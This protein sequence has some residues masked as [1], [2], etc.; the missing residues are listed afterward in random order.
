MI[1]KNHHVPS[2]A[3]GTWVQHPPWPAVDHGLAGGGSWS[4]SRLVANYAMYNQAMYTMYNQANK[5]TPIDVK[6]NIHLKLT[7]LVEC[8]SDSNTAHIHVP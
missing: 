1:D 8:Q 6:T 3:R 2:A 4:S 5:T 7:P